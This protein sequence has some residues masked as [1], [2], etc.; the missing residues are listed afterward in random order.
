MKIPLLQPFFGL[1]LG[2][3]ALP[4]SPPPLPSPPLPSHLASKFRAP[5]S[6]C[7][8]SRC[9]SGGLGL[10]TDVRNRLKWVVLPQKGT[11]GF[12]PQPYQGVLSAD[13]AAA[14]V[15]ADGS[16]GEEDLLVRSLAESRSRR[17]GSGWPTLDGS[18]VAVSAKWCQLGWA[19]LDHPVFWGVAKLQSS[20]SAGKKTVS[21]FFP[22]PSGA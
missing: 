13:M 10:R 14:K 7:P 5:R 22:W 15:S 17:Q 18:N 8:D 2:S 9:R 12:D 19:M 4:S 21:N 3:L 11:I 1:I 16:A 6:Q 20:T